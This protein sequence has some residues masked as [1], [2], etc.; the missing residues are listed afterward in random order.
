MKP[1]LRSGPLKDPAPGR[2]AAAH[3]LREGPQG[4]VQSLAE[5]PQVRQAAS[6]DRRICIPHPPQEHADQG[7]AVVGSQV[8]WRAEEAGLHTKWLMDIKGVTDKGNGD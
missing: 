2:A 4:E 8:T 6:P 5:L 3:L 1:K 7:P